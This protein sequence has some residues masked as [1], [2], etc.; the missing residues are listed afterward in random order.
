[1]DVAG[2]S[3]PEAAAP[4]GS[5]A[6]ALQNYQRA[7]ALAQQAVAAFESAGNADSSALQLELLI[8]EQFLWK[9]ALNTLAAVPPSSALYAR[10]LAKQA[11]YERLLATAES[12]LAKAN[13]D[14][15][16]MG[17][18]QDAD[19]DPQAVHITLCQIESPYLERLAVERAKRASTDSTTHTSKAAST[20]ENAQTPKSSQSQPQNPVL[21]EPERSPLLEKGQLNRD[22]C[23]HYQGDQLMASPASLIKIPIAVALAQ[24][25]ATDRSATEVTTIEVTATTTPESIAKTNIDLDQ[26]I[27]IDPG[28]FTENA[29]GAIIEVGQD[30]SLRTVMSRMI[31]DSDNIAT[32]QLIDYLGYENIEQSLKQLGYSQTSVGHKLAGDQ[33]IPQDFGISSNQSSTHEIT[34]MMAQIYAIDTPANRD[35]INALRRQADR[36]LGHEALK[37]DSAPNSTTDSTAK[38]EIKWL[39]EKTGQNAEVLASTLAISIGQDYYV[40]TIALD[41]DSNAHGLRQIIRGIADHLS[42]VG[43][44]M[45]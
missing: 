36:E 27:H 40:L 23:R 44:L 6:V 21:A 15:F 7:A 42:R 8:K 5:E 25:S 1:M 33:V 35:I 38:S 34:A 16:L 9:K 29:A 22:R 24:R 14:N 41:H 28:N 37:A 18:I 20:T 43:P 11:Q 12:K 31:M 19:V 26:K 30:Y 3:L 45:S 4:L 13:D 2:A 32:N 39:G 10:S 17:V